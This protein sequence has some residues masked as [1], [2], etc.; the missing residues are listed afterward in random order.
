M[1]LINDTLQGLDVLCAAF[2]FL[3]TG[4]LLS[5]QG[6]CLTMTLQQKIL[7][8]EDNGAISRNL[9][10][11]TVSKRALLGNSYNDTLALRGRRRVLPETGKTHKKKNSPKTAKNKIKALSEKPLV[12]FRISLSAI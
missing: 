3:E 10:F 5:Q 12:G 6:K 4:L 8:D 11:V 2:F 7:L 9:L 1:A